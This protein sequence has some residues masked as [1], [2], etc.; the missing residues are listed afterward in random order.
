MTRFVLDVNDEWSTA[1]IL[2]EHG[3]GPVTDIS[4]HIVVLAHGK[5]IVEGT[6]AQMRTDA[7]VIRTC[8]GADTAG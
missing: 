8:L 4:Q 5:K 7:L 2:I 6:P 1:M 3:M